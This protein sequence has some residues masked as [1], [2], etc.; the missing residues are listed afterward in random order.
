MNVSPLKQSGVEEKLWKE[1]L[2]I[3]QSFDKNLICFLRGR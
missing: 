2:E 1:L 3:H